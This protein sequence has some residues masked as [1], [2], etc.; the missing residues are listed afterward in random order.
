MTATMRQEMRRSSLHHS[1]QAEDDDEVEEEKVMKG[2][3]E[4][5]QAEATVDNFECNQENIPIA[6][7]S[8]DEE[9]DNRAS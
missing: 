4:D 6:N 9:K 1:L 5:H 7:M 3:P 8:I 2:V